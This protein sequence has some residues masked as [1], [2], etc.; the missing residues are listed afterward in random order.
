MKK[1]CVQDS[2][3]FS[4]IKEIE[5]AAEV[6]APIW[7]LTN[8]VAVNPLWDLRELGFHGAIRHVR[9]YLGIG[10]YLPESLAD[11]AI[12]QSRLTSKDIDGATIEANV[13]AEQYQRE[14]EPLEIV[15]PSQL[16]DHIHGTQLST[17]IEEEI[18]KWCASFLTASDKDAENGFYNYW[19]RHVVIDPAA[20]KIVGKKEHKSLGA[21]GETPLIAI[22]KAL[23]DLKNPQELHIQLFRLTLTR[24]LGWAGHAKWRS[25][26]A[27]PSHPGPK[28]YLDSLLAV[29]LVYEAVV[30]NALKATEITSVKTNASC[31]TLTLEPKSKRA[32]TKDN[33]RRSDW[34][35]LS[36]LSPDR[37][38]AV[39]LRAYENHYRDELLTIIESK[40]ESESSR[41]SSNEPPTSNVQAIFCID[42]RSEGIR[43]QLEATEIAGEIETYGFAGFFGIPANFA[44]FGESTPIALSPV[45]LQPTISSYELPDQDNDSSLKRRM[46]ISEVEKASYSAF[47]TTR[48]GA[49]SA[50]VLAEATGFAAGAIA[51]AR[52]ISPRGYASIRSFARGQSSGPIQTHIEIGDRAESFTIDE[53]VNMAENTLRAMGLIDNFA[54]IVLVC[55]HGSSTENNAFFSAFHCGAC[56]GN[57]GANS[58]RI[59]A[60]ILNTSDVRAGLTG[61][62]IAIPDTTIFIAG[63]HDTST[64]L[65]TLL[66]THNATLTHKSEIESL[67]Q[68]LIQA[69]EKLAQERA[70]SLPGAPARGGAAHV[71]RRASDWAQITPEW[72]LARNAAM[73]IGPRSTTMGLDLNRR[74]FLHS[75]NASIDPDGTL[76]TAILTAPMVVAHWINAQYYF[77]S[78]DAATFSAGDK[79]AHNVVGGTGVILGAGG[80]LMVGLTRQSLFDQDMAYHEPMRLLTLVEA[81]IERIE[82]VIDANQILQQLFNGAWVHLVAR[83]NKDSRWMIRSTARQWYPWQNSPENVEK[84]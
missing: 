70:K 82:Q 80:D 48:H 15:L 37:Q 26:W 61:R 9:Q 31:P 65:V 39:I 16:I 44:P 55:G 57:R 36:Q 8:F 7:P 24:L 51:I 19:R 81:P 34:E 6:I 2:K 4:L 1:E 54:P 11:L 41:E 20:R 66:D 42:V 45:L 29:G 77:S 50:Y 83:E 32:T 58:A 22:T 71:A 23:D 43:R 52:T 75:Y 53:Q 13:L 47:E 78:V 62:G 38:S 76:L 5:Q 10:G 68:A 60:T 14:I 21:F 3:P 69:G 67:K 79:V 18:A 27:D 84:A 74:T 28:L 12:K 40:S 35:A 73:I 17:M 64:D 33:S 72:G 46:A 59:F 56:G 63:E 49:T 30:A 25:Q